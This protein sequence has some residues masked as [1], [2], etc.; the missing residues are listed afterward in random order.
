MCGL[1]S[2]GPGQRSV[3][4]G[5]GYVHA[6]TNIRVPQKSGNSFTS[7]ISDCTL[8][9]DNVLHNASYLV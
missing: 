1:D 4:G 3:G 2:H 9:K 5:G 8:V 6:L 7:Q